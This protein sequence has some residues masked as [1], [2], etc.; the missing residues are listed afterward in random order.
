MTKNTIG[1]KATRPNMRNQRIAGTGNRLYWIHPQTGMLHLVN[2][3]TVAVESGVHPDCA[4][5]FRQFNGY[6]V[7]KRPPPA[8]PRRSQVAPPPPPPA[9]DESETGGLPPDSDPSVAGSSDAP[10]E[11][12]LLPED[13]DEL[14]ISGW[15]SLADDLGLELSAEEQATRP[16]SDL[17]ALIRDKVSSSQ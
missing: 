6:E 5:R 13:A 14:T 2:G 11:P 8:P 4:A 12:V 9:S 16:K 1:V 3:L 7:E 15:L 10:A 17:V